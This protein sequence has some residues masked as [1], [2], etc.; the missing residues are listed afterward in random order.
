METPLR[1]PPSGVLP[2]FANPP[3][4]GRPVLITAG[5]CLPLVVLFSAVRVFAKAR[6]LKKW[7]LDDIVYC[8]SCP[9][10]IAMIAFELAIVCSGANAHHAWDIKE[11]DVSK[12]TIMNLLVFSIAL[13]PV[14]WLLKLTLFCSILTAFGSVRWLKNCAYMGIVVTGLFFSM[15][16]I[17]VTSAC[18]PRPGTDKQ[19]YIDG[20]NRKQCSASDGANAIVSILTSIVNF[21][22]DLYLLVIPLPAI[23]RLSLAPKQK[24][25]VWI[26]MLSGSLICLCSMLGIVYRVKAW[27]S[28]D[29]TGTQIPIYVL[30][31]LELALSL[32][33][34]CM[35]SVAT[36][37]RHLT[38]LD[39]ND[40]TT[41]GTPNKELLSTLSSPQS[42]SRATWRKTH[43]SIEEMPYRQASKKYRQNPRHDARMK[44]LPCT[45]L[46]L[47]MHSAPQTP[48]SFRSMRLPIMFTTNSKDAQ[49]SPV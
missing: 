14:L 29:L 49:Q 46:P 12:A 33:I 4:M 43:L 28:T 26:I 15:Y 45:P 11:L 13:G 30:F 24:I 19:S 32:M 10:G 3:Y 6:I 35:P 17:V 1:Q 47:G 31:M 40:T 21:S 38:R 39:I 25:G 20:V 27:Q 5:I 41:I 37:Y 9:V 22:S 2:N 7:T 16:T 23:Y 42:V 44:A 8:I 18:G 48:T 34:P 36:V